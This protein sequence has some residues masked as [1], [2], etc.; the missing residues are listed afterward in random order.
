M[1][2]LAVFLLLFIALAPGCVSP[3]E[4]INV[5]ENSDRQVV[6]SG[7]T[8][9]VEY[10]GSFT[11]GTVFDSS[12]GRE[13]LQFVAG[14][15]QMI[16]GF[17]SA[18][19]GMYAGQEKNVTLAPDLAY[20]YYDENKTLELPAEQFPNGTKA[21]DNL[22]YGFNQVTVMSINSTSGVIDMNHPL[23]GETLVFYIRLLSIG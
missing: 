12:A 19:I 7:D 18:V 1:K 13:P 14:S 17:D 5:S 15:G 6:K 10:T 9:S 11:N 21:G 4:Q 8:V 16:P 20:G 3:S 23:A 2:H 22:Y